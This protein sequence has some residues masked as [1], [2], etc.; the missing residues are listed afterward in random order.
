MKYECPLCKV[1]LKEKVGE[2]MHPG[3]VDY[4]ITLDCEN[5]G[6][7]SQEV[8]GHGSNVKQAYEVILSKFVRREERGVDK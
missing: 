5:V 6:C 4:G 7:T 2:K 3:N 1:E 8:M